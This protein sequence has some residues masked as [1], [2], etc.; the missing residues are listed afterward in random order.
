MFRVNAQNTPPPA[1]APWVPGIEPLKMLEEQRRA[2]HYIR[3]KLAHREVRTREHR[4]PKHQVEGERSDV[5]VDLAKLH[6][7]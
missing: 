5:Q 3:L 7:P 2:G 4:P 1:S 6:R